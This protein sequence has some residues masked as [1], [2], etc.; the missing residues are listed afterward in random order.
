MSFC[1]SCGHQLEEGIVYCPACGKRVSGET[2]QSHGAPTLSSIPP[3]Y[4]TYDDGD[5]R[6]LNKLRLLA[7]IFLIGTV[8]GLVLTFAFAF[9]GIYSIPFNISQLDST[10]TGAQAVV[11]PNFFS[12]LFTTLAA[13]SLI[14]VVIEF[15]ALY[16]LRSAFNSLAR[17]GRLNFGIPSKLTFV[18]LIA[19]PILILGLLITLSELGAILSSLPQ[20]QGQSPTIPGGVGIFLGAVALEGIG[21]IAV[22]VEYIG[23]VMLGIWRMGARYKETLFKV[24]AIFL[25]IPLLQLVAPILILIG[26]PSAKAKV[27]H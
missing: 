13:T 26:T 10:S 15:V 16:Q 25:I 14:G 2:L 7:I 22:L 5:T 6:A 24:A 11:A 27:F 21:G 9:G 18:V 12:N 23:G 3:A 17:A 19:L 1:S 4:Q 20:N 8:T